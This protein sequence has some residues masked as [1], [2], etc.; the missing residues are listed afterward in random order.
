MV[1]PAREVAS[2]PAPIRQQIHEGHIGV[3]ASRIAEWFLHFTLPAQFN[4]GVLQHSEA[5][6]ARLSVPQRPGCAS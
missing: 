6:G 5:D 3:L 2:K 4:G 1:V